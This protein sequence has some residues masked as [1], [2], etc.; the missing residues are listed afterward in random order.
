[1]D[2]LRVRY[3]HTGQ[4]VRELSG[5]NQQKIA[6]TR[7]LYHG[8]DVLLLDEPTRGIDIGSKAEVYRLI[9]QLARGDRDRGVPPESRSFCQQLSARAAR[10]V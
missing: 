8:C 10:C 4:P 9:D 5:G 7:L 2:R 1:M 3:Q 6:L